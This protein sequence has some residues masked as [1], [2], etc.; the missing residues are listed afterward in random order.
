MAIERFPR[1]PITSLFGLAHSSFD[2]TTFRHECEQFATFEAS[3]SSEDLWRFSLV[4]AATLMVTLNAELTGRKKPNGWPEYRLLAVSCA[5]LSVCWWDT[6]LKSAHVNLQ[7]WQ[8]ERKEFDEH[9]SD[10]LSS[11]VEA[12]G[13]PRLQGVDADANRRR[14]AVWRGETGLLVLQ[15]SAYDPQFGHDVNYWVQPWSGS[16]P[17]P[18]SPFIDWLRQSSPSQQS[19]S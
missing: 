18:T 9:Y 17:E 12:L 11:A 8:G 7:S 16:D 19:K 2:P 6:F 13:P 10:S 4:G 15:Q 1:P 3:S 5:I 14:Y